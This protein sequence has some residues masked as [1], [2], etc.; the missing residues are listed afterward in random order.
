MEEIPKLTPKQEGFVKD[1]LDGEPGVRAALNNYDTT[2]YNTAAAIASENL[3]KPNIIERL[4]AAQH[5]AYATILDLAQNAEKE[6]VRLRA[7]QDIIDRTEG[8]A[9]QRSDIT[10]D[11]K[12]IFT[13]AEVILSKNNVTHSEAERDSEG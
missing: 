8:K 12:P 11:G 4:R 10:S 5:I 3:R 6:D 1:V 13:V 9:T 7:S 2:D